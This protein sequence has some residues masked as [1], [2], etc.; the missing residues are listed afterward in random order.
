MRMETPRQLGSLLKDRRRKAGLTQQDLADR[1][2]GS[3][4]W[5]QRAEGGHTGTSVGMLMRALAA[6]GVVLDARASEERGAAHQ[7]PVADIDRIVARAKRPSA[8]DR[9]EP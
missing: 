2:Q 9:G 8:S 7:I 3:L 6:V 4:R 5:V 1:I